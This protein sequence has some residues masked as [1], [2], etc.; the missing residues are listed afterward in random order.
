MNLVQMRLMG[1]LKAYVLDL[2]IPMNV[3][4]EMDNFAKKC[5][6]LGE[7]QKLV[8]DTL[9]KF[10]NLLRDT[11]IIKIAKGIGIDGPEK[12]SGRTSPQRA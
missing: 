8:V 5:I 2:N 7:K 1:P 9:L 10:P 12:K 4:P 3:I 11:K 6:C